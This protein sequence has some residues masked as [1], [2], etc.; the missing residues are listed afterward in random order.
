MVRAKDILTS[1]REIEVLADLVVLITGMV[2]TAI[3]H[4]GQC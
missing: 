2:P 3:N 4:W 1:K